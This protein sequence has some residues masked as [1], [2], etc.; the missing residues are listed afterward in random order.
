MTDDLEEYNRQ[1][2]TALN[3]EREKN[4]QLSNAVQQQISNEGQNLIQY[5]LEVNEILEQVEHFLKGQV[6]FTN[7]DGSQYW[8]DPDD[9]E[10]QV[11][12]DKGVQEILRVL[13]LYLN[14]NTIL[15]NYKEDLI[16]EKMYDLGIELSDLL[17]IKWKEYGL[18]TEEKQKM[19]TMIVRQIVDTV[20]S[21]Y[22][23]ALGGGERDSLRQARLVTQ[24]DTTGQPQQHL[25]TKKKFSFFRPTSWG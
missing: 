20:H 25:H 14:K 12:N 21:S 4:R 18:D 11:L 5:Q 7:D 15:S 10:Q 2:N 19:Y 24:Q 8:K 6:V 9:K 13:R 22:L 16:N 23:R 17:Y 1:L 3:E